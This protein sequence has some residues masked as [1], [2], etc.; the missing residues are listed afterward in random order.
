MIGL[1]IAGTTSGAGK[2][3]VT[4]GL[5]AALRRRGLRVQG[6]KVGPDFI[7]PGLH[8]RVTGRP[9]HTL[10]GGL[11]SE[12]EVRAIFARN[13]PVLL[14]VDV[15]ATV[16]SAAATLSGFEAFEITLTQNGPSPG[17]DARYDRLADAVE[18]HLDVAA[19]LRLVGRE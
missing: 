9:S 16:R 11:L 18:T 7:D 1:L 13:L 6:F 14:F 3:T 4:L 15:S 10:D 17:R 12:H 19:I 8:A 5:I 2:T